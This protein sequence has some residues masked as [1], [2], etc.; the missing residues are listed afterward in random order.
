MIKKREIDIF[1]ILLGVVIG[2]ILGFF[3]SSRI[4]IN[5]PIDD[6]GQVVAQVGNVYLLQIDKFNNPEDAQTKLANI[7]AKGLYAVVVFSNEYYYIYG[8]ISDSEGGLDL[9]ATNFEDKGYTTLIKK[10]YI[11]DRPNSVIEDDEMYVFWIECIDN[12]I[13]NLEGDEIIISNIYLSDPVHVDMIT[14]LLALQ[15]IENEVLLNRF[16]LNAYKSIVE[17]LG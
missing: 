8:G 15:N 17:T 12:L 9:L 11:I 1:G 7:Q 4:D 3:L 2:C 6:D 13:S 10:E 14:S 16:R 5:Q